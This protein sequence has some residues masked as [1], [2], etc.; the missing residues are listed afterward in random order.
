MRS[1]ISRVKTAIATG[2][3]VAFLAASCGG[4][5]PEVAPATNDPSVEQAENS[6]G[7]EPSETP[8]EMPSEAPVLP[9]EEQVEA[10]FDALST[11]DVAG[12]KRA[13]KVAEKGSIAHAY[14]GYIF[15]YVNAG[16]D[17]GMPFEGT[18]VSEVE[19][20]YESCD[21]NDSTDCVTWT[22]IEGR[23]GKIVSFKVNGKPIGKRLSAG[24]GANVAAGQLASV[25]FLYAYQSIQSG[26]MNVA[27]EIRSRGQKVMINGYE[28]TYRDPSGRQITASDVVGPSELA[29]D[30]M[31]TIAMT[32]PNARPGG[33]VTLSFYSEDFMTEAEAQFRTR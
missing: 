16:I 9:S 29:G 7:A 14:A 1:V 22:H 2:M 13:M 21:V 28:A 18:P 15:A 32:F 4:D 27:V 8:S 10:Y 12:L 6:P 33:A 23:D 19:K 5:S 26:N 20:G 11:Y 17:S 25:K 24:D 30:S 3:A 31:T